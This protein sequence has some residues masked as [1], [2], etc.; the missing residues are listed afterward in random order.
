AVV[1]LTVAPFARTELPG[2]EADLRNR[3]HALDCQIPHQLT[4][5]DG[6]GILSLTVSA[7]GI[8]ACG[9]SAMTAAAIA[10]TSGRSARFWPDRHRAR[11]T[12]VLPR[13]SRPRWPVGVL[14]LCRARLPGAGRGRR[15]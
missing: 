5:T 2:P 11:E 7:S 8:M 3:R 6:D 14:G 12:R 9:S 1:T 15:A 10:R 4:V 13:P